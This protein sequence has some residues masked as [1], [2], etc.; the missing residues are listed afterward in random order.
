[1]YTLTERTYK[2]LSIFALLIIS[3][4]L[5]FIYVP[6]LYENYVGIGFEYNYSFVKTFLSLILL[7]SSFFVLFYFKTSSFAF[8]LSVFIKLLFLIPSLV[9]YSNMNDNLLIPLSVYFFDILTVLFCTFDFKVDLPK[10]KEK[11]HVPLLIIALLLMIFPFIMEFGFTL[12]TKL[13]LL[14]DIYKSRLE[15]R[16]QQ[17][18][19]MGYFLFWI[20]KVIA[21]VLLI[22]GLKKRNILLIVVS[23]F[24]LLYIYLVGGAHRAIFFSVF[25]IIYFYFLTNYKKTLVFLSALIILLVSGR[26]FN[27]Y[28]NNYMI[29]DLLVRRTF[30]DPALLD[31]NY[32][33]FFKNNQMHLSHSIFK[34]FFHNPYNVQPSYIIGKLYYNSIENNAGNGIISDGFMNFG[35]AGIVVSIFISSFI[36]SFLNSMKINY[37]YMGIFFLVIYGYSCIGILTNLLT[38]G[39]FLTV[40]I[41][42]F[43]LKDTEKG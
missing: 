33:D 11:Y 30:F 3:I 35:I 22:Y 13:F 40:L 31:V 5:F 23:V 37:R 34:Y 41:S 2:L 12:N 29:E 26:M 4:Y 36:L 8:T 21:P 14:E 25:V 16:S 18:T 24:S 1:M 28:L 20:S 42:L 6:F 43:L 9:L 17:S 39:L 19:S 7:L 10:V 32:F 27:L 38:G 15:V